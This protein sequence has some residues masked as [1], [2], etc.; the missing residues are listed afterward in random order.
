MNDIKNKLTQNEIIFFNN[1]S[2]YI[3]N[4]ICPYGSIL[5]VDYVKGKSDIDVDIFTDN[6]I[7]TIQKLCTFLNVKKSDFVK[8]IYKI[9]NKLINGYKIKYTNEPQK[10]NIEISVYNNKYKNII[11][12]HHNNHKYLSFYVT[13]ILI[14]VKFLYYTMGIIPD[15]VYRKL[16]Q[17]LINRNSEFNFISVE[18]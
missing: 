15:N 17:L 2:I 18:I 9:N 12:C 10:L 16:K 13:F 8:I 1:L 11:G 5:R 4:E 7:S 14:V 3:D 6:E